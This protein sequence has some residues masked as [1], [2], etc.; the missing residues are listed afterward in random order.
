MTTALQRMG[1]LSLLRPSPTPTH[2][3]PSIPARHL[4]IPNRPISS[5]SPPLTL[6]ADISNVLWAPKHG[7]L[8]TKPSSHLTPLTRLLPVACIT[9]HLTHDSQKLRDHSHSLFSKSALDPTSTAVQRQKALSSLRTALTTAWKLPCND[10]IKEAYWR[11]TAGITPGCSF[12]PWTCPC[13]CITPISPSLHSFWDCPVAKAIR[14][15]LQQCLNHSLTGPPIP[16]APPH[17]PPATPTLTRAALWLHK[18]PMPSIHPAAWSLICV[19][20][21]HA[22]DSGRRALWVHR[23]GAAWNPA[24]PHLAVSSA[25]VAATTTFWAVLQ[26]AI[27]TIPGGLWVLPPRHPCLSVVDGQLVLNI[28]P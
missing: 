2:L 21:I 11:L 25:T 14:Q 18:P 9:H 3:P 26:D 16:P 1:P 12:T 7:P 6:P 15:Q 20:A 4:L 23:L 8:P 17:A 22:M 27:A 10:D 28:P 13:A 5:P 19:A 24:T